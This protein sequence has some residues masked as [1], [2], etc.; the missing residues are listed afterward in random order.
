M[1]LT[2]KDKYGHWC[3][4]GSKA[5]LQLGNPRENHPSIL[6]GDAVNKL[7][8]YEDAEE[9]GRLVMLPCKVGDTVYSLER[10]CD[11]SR[12]DCS[13]RVSCK[14]CDDYKQQINPCHIGSIDAA[15][16]VIGMLGKTVFLTREEAEAA[17]K[18]GQD[19]GT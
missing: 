3:S 5:S 10:F 8:A 14:E 18:G 12:G 11:G 13:S 6:W 9:Q 4:D 7:A 2:F 15:F 16:A 17:L 19:D 1:R